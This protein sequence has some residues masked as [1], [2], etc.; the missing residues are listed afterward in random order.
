MIH[1][2][3]NQGPWTRQSSMA[4]WGFQRVCMFE[5]G[6]FLWAT[7]WSQ[8]VRSWLWCTCSPEPLSTKEITVHDSGL[9][10]AGQTCHISGI[11]CF[12]SSGLQCAMIT[13]SWRIMFQGIASRH[14]TPRNRP[15]V[16]PRVFDIERHIKYRKTFFYQR[17]IIYIFRTLWYVIQATSPLNQT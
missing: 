3:N 6:C 4:L 7:P 13:S 8:T 14:S 11:Y 9:C 17:L 1:G 15:T 5:T 16:C 2:F 10:A 12:N